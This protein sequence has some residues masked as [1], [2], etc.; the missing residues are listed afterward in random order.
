[1]SGVLHSSLIAIDFY[2]VSNPL[3]QPGENIH[4]PRDPEVDRERERSEVEREWGQRASQGM[5]GK[6]KH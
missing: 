6:I 5:W 4:L 3:T 2:I 1:M